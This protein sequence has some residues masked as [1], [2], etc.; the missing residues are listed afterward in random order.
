MCAQRVG[1]RLAS[2]NRR[3]SAASSR[4]RHARPAAAGRCAGRAGRRSPSRPDL[5][6]VEAHRRRSRTCR[7]R[8]LVQPRRAVRSLLQPPPKSCRA[9]ASR[10]SGRRAAAAERVAS[11]GRRAAV[12]FSS[13]RL[14]PSDSQIAAEAVDRRDAGR[15]DRANRSRSVWNSCQTLPLSPREGHSDAAELVPHGHA[16]VALGRRSR[17]RRRCRWRSGRRR[18]SAPFSRRSIA[19]APSAKPN[20]TAVLLVEPGD[21]EPATSR[22]L[23]AILRADVQPVEREA[24]REVVP[25]ADRHRDAEWSDLTPV[26]L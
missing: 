4:S 18:R 24:L 22:D 17:D 16:A 1:R 19:F 20:A 10:N 6:E 26:D 12:C 25:L 14:R 23:R 13:S 21:R 8:S 11:C 15:S 9:S 2:H 5:G 7:R 3:R